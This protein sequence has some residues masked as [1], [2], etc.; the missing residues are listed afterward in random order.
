MKPPWGSGVA[1]SNGVD[2]ATAAPLPFELRQVVSR[3]PVTVYTAPNCAPCDAG[4]GMLVARGIPFSERSVSTMEDI[5]ALQRISGTASLPYTLTMVGYGLGGVMMGRLADRV[6]VSRQTVYNEIGSKQQLGEAMIMRELEVFLR[7]VDAAFT[8]SSAEALVL[9]GSGDIQPVRV[10]Q[11]CDLQCH[12][13]D[14]CSSG[15][16]I[17]QRDLTVAAI[18]IDIECPCLISSGIE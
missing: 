13:T 12:S 7:N 1:P 17:A 10:T 18:N 15:V 14:E 11:Q 5:E 2:S 16:V 8:G 6:G 3:Y 9:N 4:R